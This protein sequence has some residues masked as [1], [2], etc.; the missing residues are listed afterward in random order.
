[1]SLSYITYRGKRIL[2][3]D[4]TKCKT[5]Q[6]TIDVLES[7]RNEYLHIEGKV[8][9]LNDF[10]G[11]SANNEYMDLAKKYAKELFDEKTHKNACLG[12]TGVRKILLS[13]YNLVVKNKLM[14]FDT[15]EEALEYL[16]N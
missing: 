12:V 3:I 2:L 10:T 13:A 16:V 6:D 4:Y 14:P 7:V 9:A 11:V 8:I 5:T 15:R 1:M